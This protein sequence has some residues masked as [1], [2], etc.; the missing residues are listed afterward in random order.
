VRQLEARRLRA[1]EFI[2]KADVGKVVVV[3]WTI[4]EKLQYDRKS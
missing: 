1:R 4:E 3:Q 2:M